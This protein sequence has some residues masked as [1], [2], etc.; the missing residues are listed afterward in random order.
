MNNNINDI[1]HKAL[2]LKLNAN[3]QAV[4]VELVSKSLCDLMT[5]VVLAIDI[6]YKTNEDGSPNF[7]EYEYINPVNWETW[8]KLKVRDY[9]L[10]IHS[11]KMTVRVPTV[12]IAKNYAKMPMRKF[13]KKPT[14][15]GLRIRDNN[16]DI[17]T[18]KKLGDND[19][20]SIDH[21]LPLSK[22]GTDTY[23]NVGLTTKELNNK[24][25]NKLNHEIGLKPLFTP[26]IPKPVPISQTIRKVRHHTW[27]F[28]IN[29]KYK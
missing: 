4:G 13:K 14:T 24:K 1:A 12:V 29:K 27:S 19:K 26:T 18:G 28:F 21:L 23:D 7:N 25:G 10:V 17:Y 11:T 15:E 20:I 6:V 2:V 5:G 3:F 8:I 22:G 9:D 16:I